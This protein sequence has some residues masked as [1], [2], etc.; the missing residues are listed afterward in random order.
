MT[1]E[2]MLRHLNSANEIALE[3]LAA[4]HH[5]FGAIL[6]GPDKESILLRQGNVDT[7]RHAE[8]ELARKAAA[9]YSSD[10]LWECSLVTTIEPCAMCAGTFYWAN[11]GTLIYGVS[12]ADLKEL[13]GDDP[14][15]PTM[16][17]P[18]RTVINSGQKE[19]A[20][21]GPFAESREFI[22][23]PHQTFWK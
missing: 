6:I 11:I 20:V 5:P 17:L 21:H 3:A 7:V 23:A 18:S 1:T 16:A 14:Q 13:T 22:L 2:Q 8:T 15:N 12:E 4:G 9:E 10:F 19:I